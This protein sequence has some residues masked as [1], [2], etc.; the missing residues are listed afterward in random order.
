MKYPIEIK[1]KTFKQVTKLNLSGRGLKEFPENVFEYTNLTKLV[2]SNNR[3]KVIPKEILRL[4]KLK[5]LDLANND[6]TVLQ[7]AV[8]NLPKLRTLNVYG[9][10]IKKFPKQVY[11]SNIQ[12]V[13]VGQNP[14]APEEIA[15]LEKFCEVV[16]TSIE[17]VDAKLPEVLGEDSRE[18]IGNTKEENKMEKKHSIF[19]SYSHEDKEWLTK[20]LKYLKPL[21]RFY[22]NLEVWNDEKIKAS[23]IW[24]EEI[25]NA[26]S[27]ATIAILIVSPDFESS[28]FITNEELQP[29]LEKAQKEGTKIMPLVVRPCAYFEENGL[30]KYQAV[31]DPKQPLLGMSRFEQE[32][33]LVEMVSV[34]K[35]IIKQ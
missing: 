27:Q 13:I 35:E 22:N 34:I 5:V 9:N 32:S 33:K 14:I 2:L 6:I 19:I 26:L 11:D 8:F 16:H 3:I 7:S 10:K 1:R 18:E 28:D 12:K 30:S 25:D 17:E 15:K 23:D 24:K 31:N 21:Q 29:L 4:K 20:V